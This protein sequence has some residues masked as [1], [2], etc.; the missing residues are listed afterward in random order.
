M[1]PAMQ[2]DLPTRIDGGSEIAILVV[3]GGDYQAA[4]GCR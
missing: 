3:W 2:Q 4:V 1:P